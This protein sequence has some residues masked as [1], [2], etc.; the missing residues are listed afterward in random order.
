MVT[1]A[2]LSAR[3]E[4]QMKRDQ[5]DAIMGFPE[6]L[7]ESPQRGMPSDASGPG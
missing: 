7:G 4:T 1:C 3:L 6:G 2:Q 5:I